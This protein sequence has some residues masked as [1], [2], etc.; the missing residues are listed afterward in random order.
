MAYERKIY[1]KTTCPRCNYSKA[2]LRLDVV[3]P[4]GERYLVYLVC[5]M[6][7]LTQYRF[8]TNKKAIRLTSRIERLRKALS[9]L[10]PK[11]NRA[12]SVRANIVVLLHQRRKQEIGG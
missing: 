12:R 7:R 2:E 6:C 10:D 1:E 5:P 3:N 4:T 9:E 11:T 8:S